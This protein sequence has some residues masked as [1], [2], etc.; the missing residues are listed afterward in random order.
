MSRRE[1]D[2]QAF[3]RLTNE[4]YERSRA[5]VQHFLGGISSSSAAK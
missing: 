2:R 1:G 4:N 5:L 3:D